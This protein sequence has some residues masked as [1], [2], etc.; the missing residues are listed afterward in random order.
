[1]MALLTS[2]RLA[3]G[4][5]VL[6]RTADV[7]AQRFRIGKVRQDIVLFVRFLGDVAHVLVAERA[8]DGTLRTPEGRPVEVELIATPTNN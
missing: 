8:A 4:Q 1:M 5:I 2:D 3:A 7:P 6:V